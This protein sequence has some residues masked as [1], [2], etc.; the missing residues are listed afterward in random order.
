[1]TFAR[2]FSALKTWLRTR[3][4]VGLYGVLFRS[5]IAVVPQAEELDVMLD[6]LDGERDG[7]FD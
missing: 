7:W 5:L 6:M 3:L 2:S 4:T 1:M